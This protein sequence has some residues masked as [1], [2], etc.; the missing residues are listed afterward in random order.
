MKSVLRKISRE[1]NH[2]RFPECRAKVIGKGEESIRVEFTG[3]AAS[4][5]CCFDEHF[6]DFRLMMEERG[7]KA[8]I[9]EIKR[10]SP[11][12]FIVLYV[13]HE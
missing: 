4:F 2:F 12:K 13:I 5:S 6:E 9:G 3:T 11:D 7:M 10:E 8:D 1:F